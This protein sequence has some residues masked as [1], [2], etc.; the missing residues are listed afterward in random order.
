MSAIEQ[1]AETN[2]I[3]W[4]TT[5]EESG[6]TVEG[7]YDVELVVIGAGL[8]GQA[9]P[10]SVT[11][12]RPEPAM[13]VVEAQRVGAGATGRNTARSDRAGRGAR[14]RGG[15]QRQHSLEQAIPTTPIP[16]CRASTPNRHPP[17]FR[18][19]RRSRQD[20][21]ACLSDGSTSSCPARVSRPVATVTNTDQ[22]RRGHICATVWTF[23]WRR[24]R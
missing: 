16:V 2:P 24:V 12:Y 10:Y 1:V 3:W 14:G 6:P 22:G 5:Q 4:P 11:E 21:V 23:S 7:R 9:W 17:A 20:F 15:G 19:T 13:S 8:A 18:R